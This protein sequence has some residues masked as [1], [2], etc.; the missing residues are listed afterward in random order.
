[1]RIVDVTE[2]NMADW[3]ALIEQSP[4]ATWFQTRE[5]FDFY[6]GVSFLDEFMVAVENIGSLKG[7]IVGYIQKDGGKLKQFFSKRAIILGGPLLAEDVTDEE[8]CFLLT[9]LNSKLKNKAIYIETR[10]F[11]DYSRWQK[12]FNVCGFDYQ[13]HYN[14]H[15]DTSSMEIV[16]ES[17]GKSRKRDVRVS[18]RDGA[19]VILT[20]TIEQVREFYEILSD[21]YEKKVKTPLAP[22]EYFDVLFK[23]PS[24]KYILVE[25]CG[26]IIGGTIC[27]K[28][29]N[30]AV[31]E[32]YVCGK[33]SVYKNIFPSELATYAG[34]KYAVE[35]KCPIFDMMGAGKP[36][37]GGYGVRDFKLK[38]GGKLM[39]QGR[40]VRVCNGLLYGI[41]KLGLKIMKKI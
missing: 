28:L 17:M 9:S 38:F 25:Y 24:S 27:V 4:V 7:L 32:M 40:F 36:D 18:I 1:M 29:S 5:A 14:I 26:K 23:I 11:N 19:V 20:P 34:I 30:K 39:E 22:W 37:D 41:G 8:L 13:P 15:V 12:V 33:D 10:N 35:E 16:N 3:N 6:K 21:L 2:V 31:Y